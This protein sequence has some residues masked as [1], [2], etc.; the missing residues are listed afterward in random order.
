MNEGLFWRRLRFWGAVAAV[1]VGT[2]FLLEVGAACSSQPGFAKFV[3]F[4]HR[5][6]S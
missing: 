6:A 5:G 1:S 4:T 2:H 3:A